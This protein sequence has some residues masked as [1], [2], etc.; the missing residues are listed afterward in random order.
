MEIIHFIQ[1]SLMMLANNADVPPLEPCWTKN[2]V[3]MSFKQ[4]G[5]EREGFYKGLPI[6]KDKA[7]CI[8]DLIYT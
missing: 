6:F 3:D 7:L 5:S 8:A 2:G 1:A 4:Q